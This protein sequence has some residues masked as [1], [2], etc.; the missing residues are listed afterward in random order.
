MI[1]LTIGIYVLAQ[2]IGFG[3]LFAALG[4]MD[5]IVVFGVAGAM[6]MITSLIGLMLSHKATITLGKIIGI[7][8]IAMLIVMAIMSVF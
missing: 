4:T 1:F 8:S 6:F 2:G 7:A 3:I 5:L